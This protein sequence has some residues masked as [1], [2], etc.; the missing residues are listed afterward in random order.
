MGNYYGKYEYKQ[1]DSISKPLNNYINK[2]C[3]DEFKYGIYTD[4]EKMKKTL[5]TMEIN[6][7]PDEI[8]DKLLNESWGRK[9][10]RRFMGATTIGMG[11]YEILILW[12]NKGMYTKLKNLNDIELYDLN[13]LTRKGDNIL[14][15]IKNE[16]AMKILIITDKL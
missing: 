3:K 4:Y 2:Y 1:D 13:N 12:E 7:L 9:S 16:K 5:S 14:V 11:S 10:D 8:V 15:N 6:N